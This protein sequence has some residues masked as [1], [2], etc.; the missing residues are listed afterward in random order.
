[1]RRLYFSKKSYNRLVKRLNLPTPECTAITETTCCGREAICFDN[2]RST[3]NT[4]VDKILY[5][6]PDGKW[7]IGNPSNPDEKNQPVKLGKILSKVWGL[8]PHEI[9]QKVAEWQSY[10]EGLWRRVMVSNYLSQVYDTKHSN[11]GTIGGSCM[12]G[13]GFLYKDLDKNDNVKI[14][15]ITEG[16][17]LVARAILWHNVY[18]KDWGEEINLMDRIYYAHEKYFQAMKEWA[19]KNGYWHKYRQ[20]YTEKD[21]IVSPDGDVEKYISLEVNLE[22]PLNPDCCPYL[23]TFTY[24]DKSMTRFWNWEHE[25]TR[26]HL[27][28]TDGYAGG[29]YR[30]VCDYCGDGCN[31]VVELVDG[32]IVC[33]SCVEYHEDIVWCVDIEQ[34]AWADQAVYCESDGNCYYYTDELVQIDG[35]WYRKDDEYNITVCDHCNNF[36]LND[37]PHI[38]P[39]LDLTDLCVLWVCNYCFRYELDKITKTEAINYLT[40]IAAQGNHY[41][42]ELMQD[43]VVNFWTRCVAIFSNGEPITVEEFEEIYEEV[44]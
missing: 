5:N 40:K 22:H 31:D 19:S 12:R 1:M 25:D 23:D 43:V 41:A 15:Y 42:I 33:E 17:I 32:S 4:S 28:T 36:T 29:G 7:F 18:V 2:P 13:K 10:Y 27:D 37:E 44:A 14:A 9:S 8:K 34:Y 6:N 20:S 38:Y 30:Y 21:S 11:D 35:Y 3:M 24:A 39:V 16:D 26:Y